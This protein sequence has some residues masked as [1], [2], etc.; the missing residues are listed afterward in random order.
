MD[1]FATAHPVKIYF[2]RPE[3][4]PQRSLLGIADGSETLAGGLSTEYKRLR[5]KSAKP[6]TASLIRFTHSVLSAA[7]R[8]R[9]HGPR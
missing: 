5:S 7:S 2:A 6:T 8:E 1:H 4:V 9:A 3:N